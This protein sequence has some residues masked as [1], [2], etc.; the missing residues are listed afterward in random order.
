MLLELVNP[1]GRGEVHAPIHQ[2]GQAVEIGRV[3]KRGNQ[4]NHGE[5]LAGEALDEGGLA[6]ARRAPHERRHAAIPLRRR[7]LQRYQ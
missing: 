6:R 5:A 1:L 4:G 2:H 3:V 7:R